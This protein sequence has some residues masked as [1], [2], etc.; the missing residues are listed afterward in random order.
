[1]A[2]QDFLVELGTE[3]LPPK[4]LKPLSDAFT[5]GI[6]KGLE[7]A[8]VAFGAVESFAAPR[9]LAVR[10]RDLAD[11]QPDKSVEKRGPAVKAAF[12]DAGNPT[13]AL[14]GFAT[15]LGITPD[16]LDTME[17]DKGAWLVYRTVEQGKPTVELMP[18]L[19]EKSLAALPIPKRMRWGAWK[20]EFVRP[21]HWLIQLYGNKVIDTPVMN[22][23]PGN[24]TRGHRFHCPKELIVP[25]PADYEVVL[26]QEGYVLADFA[27]RREQ[28]RAGVIAL[29]ENEA[30]GTAVIDEDLLDEV[31][32]LNEWPVP[33][34]G[35]FEERF[36]DVPAEALI[37]SM[38]E[39]QKY[40]HVVDQNHQMLPLFITVANLE[41]KDPSQV[42][43]G[44]EKV[45]R[46][47]LSDAA[48]FYETDRRSK[49]EDR[50][51]SLK[52][53]VFQDKLGSIY[54][55][56]VR[57]AAL[58]KKIA[59]AINGD[60]ALAERAAMLAKTDLCT[61]MVLE[62]TDLQGIMGQYYAI[63]DGEHEDV[64]KALNEQYMPRFAGDD[65]PTTLTGCAV[66][67]A[68]RIDSLVG[69][70]GINQPPSGTRDPFALRRASLGV[71]RIIIERA[72]PLDLQTVCEW[73]E[74]NFTVLT[75]K[76]TASTVVDYMLER[77]RAHYDEQGIG[78]EVYLAVHARRPTRPLDF[79]RRV[80]A[81]EAFRQLPE[82]Q[83]LA[84]A[85]KRVSNIL[86]KQG[87]DHIGETVDNAL[88]QDA[89]EKTLAARVEEQAQKVLPMFEQGDYASA[90]TSLASLRE[91]VD[92]FFDEVMVMAEDEAVRNNRLA[93]LNRLGNLFLRVADISLLPTAG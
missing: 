88:L 20:T 21:V 29:A 9:R 48:F 61:E 40:F 71:L 41:S 25:T 52:P 54:D 66:A 23:K 39:H 27:E 8:G 81:V 24:K 76:N 12:D 17:T 15:S 16:Q 35:R 82:A 78:A 10:I 33:L 75:E 30:G 37:S 83:A 70:F 79:D 86:T 6:V 36:L 28:I 64:A 51:E 73:A 4:A 3:E 80:K 11:A 72:L 63:H 65:L 60:P 5:Q 18:E 34:M 26:K 55:K 53:I 2:T 45:I 19:V 58:A 84:G 91:P 49:L 46:P 69:L 85:N 90:L 67:I 1:M 22:L 62:F 87:G 68:D 44:N 32:A 50:I 14:T 92:I 93:L 7:D 56:S 57:V 42:V 43:S 13:R 38:K 59:E 47:R 89:A 74:Q 31:T 77:F